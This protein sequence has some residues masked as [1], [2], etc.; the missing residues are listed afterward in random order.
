MVRAPIEAQVTKSAVYCGVIGSSISVAHGMPSSL[1]SSKSFRARRRPSGMLNVPFRCG[2]LMSPFQPTVVA[3]ENTADLLASLNHGFGG[4]FRQRVLVDQRLRRR[5]RNK[6]ANMDVG[7]T[8]HGETTAA[9]GE[10]SRLLS[11]VIGRAESGQGRGVSSTC[12]RGPDGPRL[13]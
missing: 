7:S 1:I 9:G 4:S 6:A 2:S 12:E 3:R 10:E 5:Q 11:S 13:R 8:L